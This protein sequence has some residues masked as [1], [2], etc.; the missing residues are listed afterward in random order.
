M[1]KCVVFENA[2]VLPEI[3]WYKKVNSVIDRKNIIQQIIVPADQYG[4]SFNGYI[5]IGN[6]KIDIIKEIIKINSS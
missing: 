2:V 5:N 6:N 4:I 3:E 1:E